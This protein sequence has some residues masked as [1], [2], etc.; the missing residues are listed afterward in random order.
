MWVAVAETDVQ[1]L[2]PLG[3]DEMDKRIR[4]VRTVHVLLGEILPFMWS[5]VRNR[6]VQVAVARVRDGMER[7]TSASKVSPWGC[8]ALALKSILRPLTS[9]LARVGVVSAPLLP[10]LNRHEYDDDDDDDDNDDRDG[11]DDHDC[12]DN[13]DDDDHDTDDDGRIGNENHGGLADG[14]DHD[15]EDDDDDDDEA[16]DDDDDDHGHDDDNDDGDNDDDDDDA[17][18]RCAAMGES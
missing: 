1:T 12:D 14:D 17:I 11:N 18:S 5:S 15:T 8:E 3:G 10:C 13:H 9:G 4:L 6:V 2:W 16:D 7:G